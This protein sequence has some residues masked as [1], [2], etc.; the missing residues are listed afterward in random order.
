MKVLAADIGGTHTRFALVRVEEG[1][2]ARI[3]KRATYASAELGSAL[4]G[5]RRFLEGCAVESV[6]AVCVAVAGPVEGG[7]ARLTNLDWVVGEDALFEIPGATHVCVMNDFEALGHAV[8]LL[9]GSDLFV[10]YPGKPDPRGPS[11]VLGAGTGLGQALVVPAESGSGVRVYATEGGHA[12]FAPRSDEEWALRR[13]LSRRHGHVSWER[14]L[15]GDGLH[16]IYRYLVDVGGY[17]EDDETRRAMSRRDPA[18]V[19]TERGV[20]GADPVCAR[21]LE[22]FVGCYGARAGDMAL[23]AGATGGIYVAGGI[24]PRLRD[25]FAGPAFVDAFVGN[26]RMAAWLESVPVRMIVGDD[27]ALLGAVAG[28]GAPCQIVLESP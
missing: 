16:A 19:V 17:E 25:H 9:S 5:A 3:R 22:L 10:V 27:T 7:V 4:D 28:C 11:V 18:A 20:D 13:Y 23:S 24:A 14:V 12:T 15:S 1:G 21:A 6:E 8:P 26:G 2:G